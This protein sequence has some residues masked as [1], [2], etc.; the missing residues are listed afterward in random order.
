M[1]Q[2]VLVAKSGRETGSAVSRRL[3]AEGHV[4]GV[5]Y[6][7]GITPVHLTVERRDLRIALSGAAGVNTIL[8]LQVDGTSYPA[9]VKDLQRHP[10]KRTVN[11]IDFQQVSMNEEITVTVPV[12]LTGEAKAVIAE[13]G[14]VDTAVDGLEVLTT[15][16]NMPSE[17]LVDITNMQPGD[18]IRLGDLTLPA[19]VRAV[20]EDDLV[21]VSILHTAAEAAAEGESTAEGESAEGDSAE[22]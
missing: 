15:P 19:G 7:H 4:P 9:I 17:I 1:S 22:G 21:V 16:N 14:L 20:A 18:V 3:R 8:D 10:V 11:H 2:T 6:G 5:L 13:G 12:H